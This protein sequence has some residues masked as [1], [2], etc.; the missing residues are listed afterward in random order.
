MNFDFLQRLDARTTAKL[1][2]FT[3]AAFA[4]SSL[5]GLLS[6]W[7]LIAVVFPITFVV[8]WIAAAVTAGPWVAWL[9]SREPLPQPM[10]FVAGSAAIGALVAIAYG[11]GGFVF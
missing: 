3:S 4:S 6:F 7:P 5:L 9:S 1:K 8:G 2:A 11:I 10:I